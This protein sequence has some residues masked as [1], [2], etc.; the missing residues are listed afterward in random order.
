MKTR[1]Q[2]DSAYMLGASRDFSGRVLPTC[3]DVMRCYYLVQ[4]DT[5]AQ[6]SGYDP[7]MQEVA[8]VV[9]DKVQQVWTSASIPV[10]SNRGI[11]QAVLRLVEK[12]RKVEKSWKKP[13][14][15]VQE[16]VDQFR[17]QSQQLF[18]VA[19]CKCLP[20]KPLCVCSPKDAINDVEVPFL[21]DQR[22]DRRMVIGGV[23]NKATKVLRRSDEKAEKKV[24]ELREA[25]ERAAATNFASCLGKKLQAL[26]SKEVAAAE[27]ASADPEWRP[28]SP[29]RPSSSCSS[30]SSSSRNTLELPTA[31]RMAERYNLPSGAAAAFATAVL[32]DVGAVKPEDTTLVV[33]R[34]KFSRQRQKFRSETREQELQQ[35]R[36]TE[37]LGLYFDGRQDKTKVREELANGKVRIVSG[38]EEHVVLLAQPGDLYLGHVSP[39]THG[40]ESLA[41]TL[42]VFLDD[43][44]VDTTPLRCVGCD[45]CTTNPGCWGGVVRLMEESLGRP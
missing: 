14:K 12:C 33:D 45:G 24:A 10:I 20:S 19:Q 16:G 4:A 29:S 38:T 41:K 3:E 17:A 25:E 8:Q 6:R 11:L 40:A 7:P 9:A 2:E 32:E 36:E 39:P 23:D 22:T 31:C 18:D 21:V 26:C 15:T 42:L 37:L 1:K 30:T 13:S 34:R 44:N 27:A 28:P 35:L 43:A 5:K